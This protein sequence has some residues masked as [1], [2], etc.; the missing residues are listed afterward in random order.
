[1]S[2]PELHCPHCHKKATEIRAFLFQH[3]VAYCED[4]GW[5]TDKARTKLRTDMW[6]MWM[7]SG[8]GVIMAVAAWVRGPY[9]IRGAMQIAVPFVA[10]PVGSGLFTWYRLANI[11]VGQPYSNRQVLDGATAV[12]A[13]AA[14]SER[15]NDV[16]LS[17]RPRPVR[18]TMR[19]YLYCAGMTLITALVLWLLSVG[20]Q[21]IAGPSNA[22]RAKSLFALLIW[23]LALW[24]CISFFRNRIR[25]RRLFIDGEVSEGVVLTQSES[26]VGSRIVYRYRDRSGSGFENRATDFSNKLYEE[27]SIHV[28]YNPLD[29]R[30][31]AALEG[32]LYQVL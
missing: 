6:A 10:L 3:G 25:E 2:Y 32:S 12:S 1:M 21:G 16:S 30:E 8:L 15:V 24:S 18:F 11:V 19:G 13:T 26:R 20:L 23:S 5:N 27:M 29:S 22:D 17:M 7:V 9:G 28:F 14:A 31:S 4:C